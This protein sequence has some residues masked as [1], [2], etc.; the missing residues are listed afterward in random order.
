M[1]GFAKIK[2]DNGA[3]YAIATDVGYHRQGYFMSFSWNKLLRKKNKKKE[4]MRDTSQK[5]FLVLVKA[6]ATFRDV[7]TLT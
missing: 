2:K 7:Y 4:P 6:Y 3:K 1:L 5:D